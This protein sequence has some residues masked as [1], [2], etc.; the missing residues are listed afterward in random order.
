M[1]V[2]EHRS[3]TAA[4]IVIPVP[5]RLERESADRGPAVITQ[6]RGDCFRAVLN[7]SDI[8][9]SLDIELVTELLVALD[10]AEAEPG[11]RTFVIAAEGPDFCVGMDLRSAQDWLAGGMHLPKTLLHRLATS[12]LITVALV[13]AAADGG[14]VGIAAACDHVIAGPGASFRLTETL[15]GLL[16]A[17]IMPLLI[18]RVGEHQAFSLTMTARRLDAD[19]ALRS[20]LVDES[21]D[22]AESALRSFLTGLR[23]MDVGALRALKA[24]R[25]TFCPLDLDPSERASQALRERF[26][27]P[28]VQVRLES[29]RKGGM[30]P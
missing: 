13:D 26:T 30:I 17:L 27:D 19:Q 4:D 11:C 23:R 16:P 1:T 8:R 12:P 5:Q 24:F 6:V 7:R 3:P 9:N 10:R 18:R 14:G 25:N 21:A 29:L 15:L 20:G 22:R 28:E 2:T